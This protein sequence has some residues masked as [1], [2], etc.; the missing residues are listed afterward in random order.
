MKSFL[1]LLKDKQPQ[2]LN[3]TLLAEHINYLKDLHSKKHLSICG[4]FSDN[5]QALLVLKAVSKEQAEQLV[6]QNPFIQNRFYQNYEIQEFLESNE[7]N[8]WLIEDEQTL[9]NLNTN[10]NPVTNKAIPKIENENPPQIVTLLQRKLKENVSYEEFLAAWLP[11]NVSYKGDASH[12]YD[13][14]VQVINAENLQDPTEIISIALIW[15]DKE[16]TMEES[17]RMAAAD[18]LRQERVAL[19]TDKLNDPKIF[20]VKNYF[21]LG[22]T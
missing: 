11:E 8:N 22:N 21:N 14:P 3:S 4:P 12:Y 13:L 5:Q 20:E 17:K 7:E 6:S 16:A 1:V 15:A 2:L 18:K 10:K 19:V 9:N